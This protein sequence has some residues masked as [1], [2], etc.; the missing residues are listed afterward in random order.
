MLAT[1]GRRVLRVLRADGTTRG[2]RQGPAGRAGLMV[3]LVA[4]CGSADRVDLTVREDPVADRTRLT[5]RVDPVVDRTSRTV[6]VADST[7]ATRS[8]SARLAGVADLPERARVGTHNSISRT[9]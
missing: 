8:V 4:M 9:A 5:V 7:K 2:F 6:R 1:A 3:R